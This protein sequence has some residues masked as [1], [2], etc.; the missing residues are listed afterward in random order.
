MCLLALFYRTVGDAPLVVGANR[1]EFYDRPAEPPHILEGPARAVAGVDKLAGGTWLGVNE[2]GLLVA[3]T[4]RPKSRLPAQPRSR[5]LLAREMLGC[6][7]AKEAIDLATQELDKGPYAGCNVVCA[8]AER[9]VVFQAGDWLRIQMLP[10][11][12]HVVTNGDVNDGRD[13]RLVYALGWLQQRH[14]VIARECL[15]ALRQLCAQGPDG[16]PA[17]CLHG[18][19]RGT[20]SSTLLILRAALADSTYLHSQGPPDQA[21]YQDYSHLLRE[22]ARSGR[23]NFK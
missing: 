14:C 8:D 22:I 7:S 20:V 4:N 16:H 15:D 3:V 12:L 2:I 10:P 9:L 19:D 1:E 6:R 23:S 21:P 13:L 18:A 11:G 17:M 5:G